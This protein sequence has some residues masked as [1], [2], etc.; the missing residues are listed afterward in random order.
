MDRER[1]KLKEKNA[2]RMLAATAHLS[3]AAGDV[4][5]LNKSAMEVLYTFG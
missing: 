1:E 2:T 4:N 5:Y 3:G